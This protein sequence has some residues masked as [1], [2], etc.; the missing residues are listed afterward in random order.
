MGI[1][2]KRD[3]NIEEEEEEKKKTFSSTVCRLCPL[4]Q[5]FLISSSLTIKDQ[6]KKGPARKK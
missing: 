2:N 4:L 5:Q 3:K 6:P 1:G